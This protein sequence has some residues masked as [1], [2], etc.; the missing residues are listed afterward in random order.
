MVSALFDIKSTSKNPSRVHPPA[1]CTPVCSDRSLVKQPA[2]KNTTSPV[3]LP[4]QTNDIIQLSNDELADLVLENKIKDHQLE[5][6]L[7]P[8]RAV[9]VRRLVFERK[10]SSLGKVKSLRTS[11]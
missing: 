3:V 6:K 5:T 4:T 8:T 1:D 11:L 9:S 7:N 10:L 2:L